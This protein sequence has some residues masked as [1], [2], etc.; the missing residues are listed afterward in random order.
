MRFEQF[1]PIKESV[2][3]GNLIALT[4]DIAVKTELQAGTLVKLSP[5]MMPSLTES[6]SIVS[7]KETALNHAATAMIAL[8]QQRAMSFKTAEDI[9]EQVFKQPQKTPA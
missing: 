1:H 3:N 4:P 6:F 8:I 7:L 2:I 5:V 9:C